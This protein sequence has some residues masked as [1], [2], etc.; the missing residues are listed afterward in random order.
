M[1]LALINPLE[2]SLRVRQE[3]SRT[4]QQELPYHFYSHLVKR[5][6]G[7]I[8][9]TSVGQVA[10]PI[11]GLELKLKVQAKHFA[12]RWLLD[13]NVIIVFGF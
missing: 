10:K 8:W 13:R 11:N 3:T 5:K 2:V 12:T 6:L 9:H 1:G 7:A 4:P